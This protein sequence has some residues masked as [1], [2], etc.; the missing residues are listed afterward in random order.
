M[1]IYSIF[2]DL[3]VVEFSSVLAGPAVGTFFAELGAKVIKIENKREGGDITRKWK[4]K[5]EDPHSKSSAYFHGV[6]WN[7]THIHLDLSQKNGL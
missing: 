1:N 2:Q 7:K 6:N 3:V 4:L 5:Q